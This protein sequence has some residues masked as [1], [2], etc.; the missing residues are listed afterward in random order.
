MEMK[1]WSYINFVGH[2]ETLQEDAENLLKQIGAWEDYGETG[3]GARGKEFMFQGMAGGVGRQHAT[4]AKTKAQSYMI[5]AA[6]NEYYA[7][8]YANPVLN[9]PKI[10]IIHQQ[11]RKTA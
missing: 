10:D 4:N 1:Y 7:E 11:K 8:D 3:W 6:V 9:L 5:D 2:M